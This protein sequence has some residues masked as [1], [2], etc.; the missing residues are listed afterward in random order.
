MKAR[1]VQFAVICCLVWSG[2]IA[3][4]VLIA[5]RLTPPEPL[6]RLGNVTIAFGGFKN[7]EDFRGTF[8]YGLVDNGESFAV[9]VT[10][11]AFVFDLD[12]K[13]IAREKVGKFQIREGK[14]RVVGALFEGSNISSVE[15][16]LIR[17]EPCNKIWSSEEPRFPGDGTIGAL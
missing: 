2:L 8:A 1:W 9:L 5:S 15:F 3:G 7:T 6:T 4:L 11:E 16:G 14:S 13:L 12:G 17:V 10:A